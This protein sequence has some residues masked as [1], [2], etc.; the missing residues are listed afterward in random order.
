MHQFYLPANPLRILKEIAHP[1]DFVVIEID[2]DH[3][4]TEIKF[5]RQILSNRDV[6]VRIDEMYFEHHV[7]LSPMIYRGW[8]D[9]RKAMNLPQSYELF[10]ELRNLGIRAHSWV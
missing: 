2:I 7:G 9:K 4:P 5:I 8:N 3:D 6:S 10:T 1:D